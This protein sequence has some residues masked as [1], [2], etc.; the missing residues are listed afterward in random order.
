MHDG[1]LAMPLTIIA[2]ASSATNIVHAYVVPLLHTLFALGTAASVVFLIHGGFVYM[3]SA[4]K[5]ERLDQAKRIIRNALI[6]LI[7]ILGAAVINEVLAHAYAAS[8]VTGD[9][10]LPELK[11]IPP[12]KV[13]SG[14]VAALIRAITGVLNNIV[15]SV[16]QPFLHALSFFTESTGLMAANSAVFNLWLVMVG[17]SDALFV[18]VVAL[19]GFH[20]MSASTFGFDE[21]EVKHLLPRFGL[22]FLGMNVSIFVIDGIISLSNVMI[23]AINTVS[24]TTPVW[25]TLS[26][27]VK[28]SG[29]QGVAALLIMVGFL[30]LSVILLVYYIGRLVTLYIGAVLSPTV[31]L[32]WLIPGFRDFAETA[33]KTYLTTI[34]VLF[35]H[36]VILQLAASLFVGMALGSENDL[37]DTLMAMV[38]GLATI[39]A[40]LKTQGIM[41]QFSYVSGGARSARKLG[42]QFMNGVGYMTGKG[43][44]AA[45]AAAG[46]TDTVQKGRAVT[47]VEKQANSTGQTQTATIK[48]KRSNAEI[49]VEAKPSTPRASRSKTGTT[50]VAP[51]AK[52]EPKT[53]K[54]VDKSERKK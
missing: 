7:I 34:F 18:L 13:D 37:P 22:V 16:A 51:Q 54:P 45:V 3:T 53:A 31:L 35:V 27:V 19:L 30:A 52:P 28:Q 25:D 11:A 44:A 5:P 15:Q 32:A 2:D 47:K 46:A 33:A 26:E 41:M 21:I 43:K 36:V 20:V 48:S 8:S 24:G 1:L 39:V 29:G 42:G 6:G 4:G 50:T 23:D 14:I 12:D 49:N 38:T 40:L 10:K 9:A 17:I